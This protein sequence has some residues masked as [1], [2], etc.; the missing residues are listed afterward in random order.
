MRRRLTSGRPIGP[1]ASVAT[2]AIVT[3]VARTHG[4]PCR[5]VVSPPTHPPGPAYLR[6]D[7]YWPVPSPCLSSQAGRLSMRDEY[8]H[9]AVSPHG[10]IPAQSSSKTT[11]SDTRL[12]TGCHLVF[13]LSR[14]RLSLRIMAV[15]KKNHSNTKHQLQSPIIHRETVGF[16]LSFFLLIISPSG[17][18]TTYYTTPF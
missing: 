13:I 8:R 1:R 5:S 17:S 16:F 3:V 11:K 6:V 10:A 7:A 4:Q 2:G 18:S 14:Q 12:G 15:L 9:R